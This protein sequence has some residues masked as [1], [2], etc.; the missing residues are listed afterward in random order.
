MSSEPKTFNGGPDETGG[1]V[2]RSTG[3]RRE[4]APQ[5]KGWCQRCSNPILVAHYVPGYGDVCSVVC[6]SI[7]VAQQQRKVG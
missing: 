5:P 3:P 4:P 1:Y 2:G 7:V 6:A